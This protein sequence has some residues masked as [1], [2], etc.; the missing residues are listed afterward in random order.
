MLSLLWRFAK[1]LVLRLS[2]R[3]FMIRRALLVVSAVGWMLNRRAVSRTV[4]LK[5]GETLVVAVTDETRSR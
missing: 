2:S 5:P 3:H 4:K 1:P